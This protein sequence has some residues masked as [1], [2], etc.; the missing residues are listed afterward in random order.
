MQP[1]NR[2]L[3]KDSLQILSICRENNV[4][5][6]HSNSMKWWIIDMWHACMTAMLIY[7]LKD[8]WLLIFL[9]LD[10]QSNVGRWATGIVLLFYC[11][12]YGILEAT[13]ILRKKHTCWYS[14][15]SVISC[16]LPTRLAI[17]L[18]WLDWMDPQIQYNDARAR[19]G[20]V[21]YLPFPNKTWICLT[22]IKLG[23]MADQ[24]FSVY[25]ILLTTETE[26]WAS[27]SWL[28]ESSN[29]LWTT[30][31]SIRDSIVHMIQNHSQV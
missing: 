15:S 21:W 8:V 31:F 11:T 2:F 10:V 3:S 22:K 28:L 13:L 29:N 27:N 14:E 24:H 19:N 16:H 6:S 12:L 1:N 20:I 30:W 23:Q 25:G 9:S 26:T 5:L 7:L 18:L 4:C 17:I